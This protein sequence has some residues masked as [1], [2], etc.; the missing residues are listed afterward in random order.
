M[1]R[2]YYKLC[3]LICMLLGNFCNL[4]STGKAYA[5]FVANLPMNATVEQLER[6]FKKFGPIKH[7]GIQVRSNKVSLLQAFLRSSLLNALQQLQIF[8]QCFVLSSNRDLVLVLWNLSLL[9]QCKV[10]L[11]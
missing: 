9:L 7:D 2:V 1:K 8:I 3:H 4:S 6:V 11:R 5:I 10:H